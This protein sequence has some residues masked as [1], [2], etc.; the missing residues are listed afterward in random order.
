MENNYKKGAEWRKWDMHVHTPFSIYQQF[1][2][3]NDE[4]WV[5]YIADLESLPNE[6]AVVGIND[7]LFVDGYEKLKHEQDNNGRLKKIKILPVVVFRIEKF[8]GIK[9]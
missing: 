6:F 9:F 5:K 1:G 8:A 3:D 2:E 4:T 7:Y